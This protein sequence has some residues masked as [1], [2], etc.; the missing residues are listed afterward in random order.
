MQCGTLSGDRSRMSSD[1]TEY[2]PMTSS[3][4]IPNRSTSCWPGTFSDATTTCFGSNPGRRPSVI[5]M[6][7]SGTIAPRKLKTPTTYAGARG[8]VVVF[9][10]SKTSSTSSTGKQKRS[11]PLRNTQYCDSGVRSSSGPSASS[12]SAVSAS[13]EIGASWNSSFIGLSGEAPHRAQQLFAR[14]WFCHVSV[15]AL[16]LAPILVAS[17]ILARHQNHR[18]HVEFAAALQFAANLE[19]VAVGHHYVQQN[20]AGPLVR[21][22]FF[23]TPRIVYANRL[24]A[25]R[26]QQPLHQLHLGW[27]VVNDEDF[28]EHGKFSQ[29]HP[30]Q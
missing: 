10:H 8:N 21:N 11:R 16:L 6:S 17:R 20:H 25:F 5:A 19:T 24:I 27:R 7:M 15:G 18:N 30:R 14:K 13:G 26:L 4:A 22:G 9:G 29:L 28:F 12:S 1:P 2:V 23:H 3:D